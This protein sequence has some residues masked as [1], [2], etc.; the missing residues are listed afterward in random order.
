MRDSASFVRSFARGLDVIHAFSGMHGAMTLTEIASESGVSASV[1]RRLLLTLVELGY[2]EQMGKRFRLL[3]KA[4]TLGLSYLQASDWSSIILPYLSR[5][6]QQLNETTAASVL[7]RQDIVHIVRSPAP[8]LMKFNF[9]IGQRFPAHATSM[10]R[11]LL[12]AIKEDELDRFC[13]RAELEA[14]T[15]HSITSEIDLREELA[16]VRADGYAFVNQE[17]EEGLISLAVPVCAR[18]GNTVA[19]I[20]VTVYSGRVGR[21][22]MVGNALEVL[23]R[24]AADIGAC[25]ND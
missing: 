21:R 4:M 22:E 3:P 16:R 9:S 19:A 15:E 7:D 2:V 12:A 18:N 20:N 25:I 24:A 6:T 5:A 11:V 10:G 23:Q 8:G 13:E 14:R 1:A 17:L